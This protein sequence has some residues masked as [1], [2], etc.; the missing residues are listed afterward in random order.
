MA[1]LQSADGTT[2]KL[3]ERSLA[4]C[5]GLEVEFHV[6]KLAE[7]IAAQDHVAMPGPPP[8]VIPLNHG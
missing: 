7:G 1:A 5:A 4:W 8:K 3:D 6:L 2:Q